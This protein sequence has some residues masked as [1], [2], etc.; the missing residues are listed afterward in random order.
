MSYYSYSSSFVTYSNI[1]GKTTGQ[2]CKHERTHTPEGTTEK[3]TRQ[4]LGERPVVEMRC[5]D[6]HG[7]VIDD[8]VI[9]SG[10]RA[11]ADRRIEDV[12]EEEKW[13]EQE[14]ADRL[15]RKRM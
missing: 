1:N 11:V 7:C 12:T 9:E 5:Y 8:R 14:E 10:D 6:S 2:A 13:R 15:Y 4:K 3:T